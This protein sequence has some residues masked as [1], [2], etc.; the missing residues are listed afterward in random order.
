MTASQ[1]LADRRTE[2]PHL[3]GLLSPPLAALLQEL[4]G[5]RALRVRPAGIVR[6]RGELDPRELGRAL[7]VEHVVVARL[8]ASRMLATFRSAAG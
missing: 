3:A 1:A 5:V 2:R 7:E 6:S 4:R 8:R